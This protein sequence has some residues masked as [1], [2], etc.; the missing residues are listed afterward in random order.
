MDTLPVQQ[1]AQ[2]PWLSL[3]NFDKF[4]ENLTGNV[5]KNIFD[6]NN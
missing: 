6:I 1:S 2:T 5:E 4:R 3:P